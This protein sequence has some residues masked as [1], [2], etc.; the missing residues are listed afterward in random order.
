MQLFC[1]NR[2]ADFETWWAIFETHSNAHR[3]AGLHLQ[4]LWINADNP[5]EV[6]FLF[7]VDDRTRAEGFLLAPEAGDGA[8]ESGVIDGDYFF[9]EEAVRY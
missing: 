8:E 6:F 1:R 4:H 2:V 5:D 7:S 3:E 9:I